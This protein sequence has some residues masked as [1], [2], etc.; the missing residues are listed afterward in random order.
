[1]LFGILDSKMYLGADN[2]IG[3][4]DLELLDNTTPANESWYEFGGGW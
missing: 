2:E 1:M 3:A 4:A